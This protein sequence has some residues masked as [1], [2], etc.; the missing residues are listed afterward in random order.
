MIKT[1][2]VILKFPNAAKLLREK[3]SSTTTTAC[4]D[5]KT[6]GELI[7]ASRANGTP[8][9]TKY[10]VWIEGYAATGERGTAQKLAEGVKADSFKQACEFYAD[11]FI[12][13]GCYDPGRNTYWG[14]RLFDNE[15]DARKSF[16]Q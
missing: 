16:G 6:K 5:A 8:Y 13:G 7:N 14:C 4:L 9:T 2:G 11:Q 10:D 1:Q 3:Q 12:E 15:E